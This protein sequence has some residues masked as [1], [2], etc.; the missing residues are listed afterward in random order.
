MLSIIDSSCPATPHLP[1]RREL[2]RIGGLA[3]GGL[4]WP[5][6]ARADGARRGA[7]LVQTNKSVVLLFLQGGPPQVETFDPKFD[8]PDTIRSC[9]GEVRTRLPGV[10][11]GGNFPKLAERA[12]RLAVVRSYSSGE[13]GHQQFVALNG[14]S[15]FKAT[16]GAVVARGKGSLNPVTGVPNHVLVIP[17]AVDARL[18]LNGKI[19]DV[20]SLPY[21]LEHYGAAGTLG[22]PYEAFAPRGGNTVLDNMTLKIPAER[23]HD[24][25]LLLQ[26][27]DD[28]RGGLE[29]APEM[30]GR[31]ALRDQAFAMLNR[32]ITAAFDLGKEDP[33]TLD[34][35]DTSR[36]FD[37]S[38]Y[39]A[40]GKHYNNKMNQ[41]RITN[42]LGRQLLLARRL[43]EAGCGFVTVVDSGWDLHGDVNNP[44]TP[45]GMA[46]LGP[47]LDHAVA[48]FLDDVGER[49]LSDRILL[50]ITGEMGRSPT[51]NT[52][53]EGSVGVGGTGHWKDVT[54]LVFAGGGLKMGQVIGKS[55]R[56]A[57]RVTTELYK[58]ANL[59][60][61]ILHTLFD[62][63]RARITPESLPGE[64]TKVLVDGKPIAGLF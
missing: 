41:S 24:R 49:G 33:R 31:D 52:R 36:L 25:R 5:G 55:D 61:T 56:T 15:P 23:L 44:N 57:S 43:C 38:D 29:R 32:G 48:A 60:A 27:F 46:I 14:D 45:Q 6:H 9:T 58:P 11:F 4:A 40:G 7:G 30:R 50:V 28:L 18:Q 62:A 53:A 39:H 1:S 13:D 51:K 12:D 20:F 10:W 16:M 2:L 3:L 47:Q 26:R 19:S 42:L 54:P 37:M 17:E 21:V 35:Y 59:L 34:R 63:G 64:L 8:V 22:R